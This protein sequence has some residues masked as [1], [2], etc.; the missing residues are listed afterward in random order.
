MA[1]IIDKRQRLLFGCFTENMSYPASLM[2][3][4]AQQH[5]WEADIAFFDD[6]S[7]EAVHARLAE[8]KPDLLALTFKTFER[9]EAVR[10][11]RTAHAR[12][13]PVVGGG[14]HVNG[15]VDD[16]LQTGLFKAA[17][18][19]DGMGV[20]A[21]ILDGY[22]SLSGIRIDGK[23]HPDPAVYSNR[24]FSPSMIERIKSSKI[25]EVLAS[26][27]CPFDC[28]FCATSRKVIGRPMEAV[29]D[30][31]ERAKTEWGTEWI[32]FHDDTF[33]YSKK[34]LRDL[35]DFL[36]E[37][38]LKFHFK[39]EARVD[40]F[41]ADVSDE[42]ADMGVEDINFGVE[43]TTQRMLDFINKNIKVADIYEAAGNCTRNNIA[44]KVNLMF[45]LPTQAEEDYQAALDFVKTVKPADVHM[46][47]FVPFPG[48]QL[49]D[50]CVANDHMPEEWSFDNYLSL[51]PNR[52]DFKG[53]RETSYFLRGIDYDLAS[54][55][56]DQI[57]ALDQQRKDAKIVETARVL[58]AQGPWVVVGSGNYFHRV[59]ERLGHFEWNNALG[60]HNIAGTESHQRRYDWRLPQCDWRD[61]ALAPANVLVTVHKG[62]AYRAI[63]RPLIDQRFGAEIPTHSCSTQEALRP[64]APHP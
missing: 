7:E 8:F 48:T 16:V 35:R 63:L 43:V 12:G 45:G 2:C 15:A 61:P 54:R 23:K 53:W 33:T 25:L 56:M 18:V 55:Y 13:I 42:L 5:G 47:F 28:H 14:P 46:F 27:G 41:S 62:H 30:E 58:D 64:G 20:F 51:N 49:F 9:R 19:G 3:A 22:R 52:S 21:D 11:A 57:K 59:V 40:R 39:V 31:L 60:W 34:R 37:R 29:I 32:L 38:D 36:A 4:L 10:V 50:Y 44:F 1:F 6:C 24:Y 26:Y 17:V